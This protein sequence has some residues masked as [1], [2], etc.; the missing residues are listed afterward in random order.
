MLLLLGLGGE[1]VQV[2]DDEEALVL[3]LQSD[4][5]AEGADVVAEVELAGGAIAR[6][7]SLAFH[8][9]A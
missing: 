8:D 9:E 6:E 7:Y 3:V 1:R 4:A 2:G 5:V